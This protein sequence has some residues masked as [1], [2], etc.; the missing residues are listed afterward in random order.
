MVRFGSFGGVFLLCLL[1]STLRVVSARV[2]LSSSSSRFP[3]SRSSPL[4]PLCC[5]T[6]VFGDSP[7]S[8]S[9]SSHSSCE[10]S[11]FPCSG[12]WSLSLFKWAIIPRH[13]STLFRACLSTFQLCSLAS[14]FRYRRF[15][16]RCLV[17]ALVSRHNVFVWEVFLHTALLLG[18][19]DWDFWLQ[20]CLFTITLFCSVV[21][22]VR[23]GFLL[24]S[25][26]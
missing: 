10:M 1:C 15:V 16:I 21:I 6:L 17:L 5:S 13:V 14:A 3:S 8:H 23:R 22:L 11:V 26:V 4:S 24:L 12:V 20:V 2:L 19:K 25:V 7:R 9:V 18:V